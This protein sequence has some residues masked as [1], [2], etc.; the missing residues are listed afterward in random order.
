MTQ[1][2]EPTGGKIE[3]PKDWF[4]TEGRDAHS[5]TWIL[6]RERPAHGYETGMR[7]QPLVGVKKA[8]GKTGRQFQLDFIADKK[9]DPAVRVL[10]T[11]DE[12][13][14]QLFT[15][16]CLETEEGDDHILYSLFWG[17]NEMDM[18]VVTIA[19][20][21][22]DLWETYAPTFDRMGAFELIDMKRFEK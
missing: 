11:C 12:R 7:I 22:K 21:R 16:V 9:K 15:R 8:T 3:R 14:Q 19:G 5:F 6:S 20:T 4:Y 18:A 17:S 1:L 10:S 13:E 2:L